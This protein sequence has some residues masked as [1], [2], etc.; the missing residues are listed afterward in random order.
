MM[1]SAG[2]SVVAITTSLT[3]RA[4]RRR[5]TTR[6]STDLP[7]RSFRTLPGNRVLP[8]RVWTMATTF[9]ATPVLFAGCARYFDREVRLLGRD[10]SWNGLL[11]A[12][13]R[14]DQV[15]EFAVGEPTIVGIAGIAESFRKRASIDPVFRAP[16]GMRGLDDVT[17]FNFQRIARFILGDEDLM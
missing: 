16:P 14:S 3:R 12:D 15:P 11:V 1:S 6:P 9:T 2:P 10:A 7:S 13:R 8:I 17:V 5:S 4:R